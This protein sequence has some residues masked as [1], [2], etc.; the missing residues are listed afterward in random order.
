MKFKTCDVQSNWKLADANCSINVRDG[1]SKLSTFINVQNSIRAV[2]AQV[3]VSVL[4]PLVGQVTMIDREKEDLCVWLNSSSLPSLAVVAMNEFPDIG[5]FP[6]SCPVAG[7][8]YYVKDLFVP[9]SLLPSYLPVGN[10]ILELKLFGTTLAEEVLLFYNLTL[11]GSIQ[12]YRTA[13]AAGL[14]GRRPRK[15]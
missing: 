10:F 11:H 13:F 3:K 8:L 2:R 9:S 7:G 5:H 4:L 1:E 14:A 6:E 15:M 12:P